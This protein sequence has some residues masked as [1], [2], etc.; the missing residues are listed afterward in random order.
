MSLGVSPASLHY[1]CQWQTLVWAERGG[2]GRRKGLLTK[3]SWDHIQAWCRSDVILVIGYSRVFSVVRHSPR[4]AGSVASVSH[5]LTLMLWQCW[6]H[7][8]NIL[9]KGIWQFSLL[10]SLLAE[11]EARWC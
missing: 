6:P 7:Y 9:R 5:C 8:H 2:V 11:S 3:I 1:V 4:P 10:C